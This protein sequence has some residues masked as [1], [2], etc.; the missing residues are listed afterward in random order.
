MLFALHPQ[1][2]P[3]SHQFMRN[4]VF[5]FVTAVENLQA[6]PPLIFIL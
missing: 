1:A 5:V 6:I 4:K 2:A 3:I